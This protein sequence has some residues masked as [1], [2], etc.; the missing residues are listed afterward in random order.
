MK[1]NKYRDLIIS[2]FL[3]ISLSIG[4]FIVSCSEE[5]GLLMG[6]GNTGTGDPYSTE[7][8]ETSATTTFFTAVVEGAVG[9]ISG[10]ATGWVLSAMGVAGQSGPNYS[11]QIAKISAQLDSI[12]TLLGDIDNELQQINQTLQIINCSEQTS[13]FQTQLANIETYYDQYND[14]LTVA[15]LGDTIPDTT[16]RNWSNAVLSS[17]PDDLHTIEINLAGSTGAIYS[18]VA[19]LNKPGE[20]SLS[21]DTSYY[22]NVDALTN[23]YFY[24]QAVALMMI[25]EADHYSAWVSAGKPGNIGADSVQVVCNANSSSLQF[26]VDGQSKSNEL[27]NSLITQFTFGGAQYTSE[28]FI[29]QY[30]STNPVVWTRSLE[31]FTVQA[32]YTNCRMPLYNGAPCGPAAGYFYTKLEDT[33]YRGLSGFTFANSTDLIQWIDVDKASNYDAIYEYLDAQGFNSMISKTVIA[34]DSIVI[35]FFDANVT[36]A[37]VPFFTS[38]EGVQDMYNHPTAVVQDYVTFSWVFYPKNQGE[39]GL[40][41]PYGAY[42]QYPYNYYTN[43][44]Y[45]SHDRWTNG[46]AYLEKCS[47]GSYPTSFE[48]TSNPVPGFVVEGQ[49]NQSVE[50]R[51]LWPV[52]HAKTTKC[53]NGRSQVNAGGMPTMCANNFTSFLNTNIPRPPTCKNTVISP[54]CTT[55]N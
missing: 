30:S 9:E 1:T 52:V 21:T 19:A 35:T 44:G 7:D 15:Q 13:S 41:G 25:N 17:I 4:A 16:M 11:Q 36:T 54:P 26:C 27:Y 20:N 8:T 43:S 3:V 38:N 31:D 50:K 53:T 49:R 14:M 46:T 51:Y 6:P 37:V 22:N 24:W 2:L 12:V 28:H 40:C 39:N 5:D 48:F 32:G 18:C 42:A 33:T 45:Q 29:F 55:L 47:N 10:E 23:Y 34:S